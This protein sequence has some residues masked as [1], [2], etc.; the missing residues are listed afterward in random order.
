MNQLSKNDLDMHVMI[1]GGLH[2]LSSGVLVLVGAFL[3]VFLPSI[4]AVSGDPDAIAV[5]GI[6]GP[7]LCFLLTA[8]A[9]PGLVTGFGLLKRKPWARVLAL[10]VGVL[11]LFNFPVGTLTGAYTIWVLGQ[12]SA[13]SYFSN[14][15]TA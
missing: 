11:A 13:T 2:V 15:K 3:L 8:L 12:Q 9:V 6:T 5:M 4:G 10:A 1:I 14:L 7:M